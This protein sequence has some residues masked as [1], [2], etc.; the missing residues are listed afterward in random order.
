MRFAHA[1]CEP[2]TNCGNGLR[3]KCTL[4]A[5][6]SS[7]L[8]DSNRSVGVALGS[9]SIVVLYIF[10]QD[11]NK[12][13]L[14][15]TIKE[16]RRALL[17]VIYNPK[18]GLI[19]IRLM[20]RGNRVAVF[21]A[22]KNGKLLYNT[23]G[24]LG[25]EQSYVQRKVNLPEYQC[26]LIDPDGKLKRFIIPFYFALE[27]E[28]SQ[29]SKDLHI[30][31]EMRDFIK[32]TSDKNEEFD[33]ELIKKS[34]RDLLLDMPCPLRS[35][36]IAMACR[37]VVTQFEHRKSVGEDEAWESVTKENAKWS[38]LIGKLEDISILSI[39][40]FFKETFR[41]KSLPKL[42]MSSLEINLK[43]IYSR[44]KGSVSE[45]IAKWLCGMGV[46]PEAI[47]TNELI[48]KDKLNMENAIE[49]EDTSEQLFL[50]DNRLYV[51]ENPKI[52]KWLAYLKK[53]FPFSTSADNIV[54]NMCWE[55]ATAWQ[56]DRQD[57]ENSNQND[58][59]QVINKATENKLRP[60]RMKFLS[61]VIFAA[62]EL[63]ICEESDTKQKHYQTSEFTQWIDKVY[64]LADLWNI[65][66]D[67]L[68]RQQV[69]GLY[70]L[71]HDSLALDMVREIREASA[72]IAPL[73]GIAGARLKRRLGHAAQPSECL[74][75]LPP[76][77][78]THLDGIK[79]DT[80]VAANVTLQSTAL[81]LQQVISTVEKSDTSNTHAQIIRLAELMVNGC[82]ILEQ[83]DT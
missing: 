17:L 64:I 46:I 71:G 75:A 67:F 42:Q 4:L 32:K 55:Y 66:N 83:L 33:C 23:S 12:K 72:L 38:I 59:N 9:R 13:L 78:V 54:A 26:V 74:A 43:F 39:I 30:L 62:L 44:G 24:L 37:V 25:A 58:V 68:A 11:N 57:M 80:A 56:N 16:I 79:S 28:H 69:I 60:S 2:R 81:V 27:G 3:K 8:D 5:R 1:L 51:E 19:D 18:K 50:D 6:Y 76:N 10:E 82:E 29:R 14:L 36:I 34:I 65:D 40:L 73:V 41:G 48:L 20:Q 21:T 15:S 49:E 47:V 63:I 77:L 31:R 70:Q 61:K 53:Q 52:F 7:T 22:T 35:M 45:L